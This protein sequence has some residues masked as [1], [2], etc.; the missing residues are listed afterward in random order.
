M[1]R[2]VCAFFVRKLPI[3]FLK[4]YTHFKRV[5]PESLERKYFSVHIAI[6]YKHFIPVSLFCKLRHG[7]FCIFF[8]QNA[9]F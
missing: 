1:R 9:L 5:L 6:F 2:L 4:K 7:I 3:F 8:L